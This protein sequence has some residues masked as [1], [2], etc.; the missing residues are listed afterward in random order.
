MSKIEF[1]RSI[2]GYNEWANGHVLDAAS[3]LSEEE[4][5]REG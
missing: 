1:I 2:Y 3:K 4:L 5:A